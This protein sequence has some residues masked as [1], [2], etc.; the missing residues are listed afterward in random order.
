MDLTGAE[1]IRRDGKNTQNYTNKLFMTQITTMVRSLTQS[2]A[3]WSV[4]SSGL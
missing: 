4:K 3:S 1:V 2:Q